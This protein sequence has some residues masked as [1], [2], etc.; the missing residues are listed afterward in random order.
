MRI[1]DYQTNFGLYY[2]D[3]TT[4]TLIPAGQI[5]NNLISNISFT[6][7]F[8]VDRGIWPRV[9]PGTMNV[10]LERNNN[11]VTQSFDTVWNYLRGVNLGYGF[12]FKWNGSWYGPNWYLDSKTYQRDEF[13]NETLTL[14]MVDVWTKMTNTI[15]TYGSTVSQ[16][17]CYARFNFIIGQVNSY[18]S[19]Y[20]RIN[21]ASYTGHSIKKPA[22]TGG[23]KHEQAGSL[24]DNLLETDIAWPEYWATGTVPGYNYIDYKGRG[25]ITALPATK[26]TN[27]DIGF[28]TEHSTSADHWCID[29]CQIQT[30][31]TGIVSAMRIALASD[32]TKTYYWSNS[33]YITQFGQ[34]YLDYSIEAVDQTDVNR[35]GTSIATTQ[36]PRRVSMIRTRLF[37]P[38]NGS[39]KNLNAM[40]PGYVVNVYDNKGRDTINEWHRINSVSINISQNEMTAEFGLYKGNISGEGSN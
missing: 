10:T 35:F 25:D 32:D 27:L 8:D 6:F 22:V 34:N 30:D 1:Q 7:G 9:R 19:N 24:L 29:E 40:I 11:S 17:T 15:F 2:Y 4:V 12:A 3:Q 37:E 39:I 13:G 28:S 33:T 23:Y 26:T 18:Y 5:P 21:L 31:T 14:S 16:Q 38:T 20:F 36:D